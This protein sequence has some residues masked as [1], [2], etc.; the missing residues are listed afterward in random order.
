[1]RIIIAVTL[2]CWFTHLA[3]GAAHGAEPPR[4]TTALSFTTYVAG[5]TVM[6]MEADIDIGRDSYRVDLASRTAGAYGVLFRGETRSTAQ[7]R[8]VGPLVAPQRF[9][10]SGHWRGTPRRTLMDYESGLPTILNLQ[11]PNDAEREPVPTALQRETIDAISAAA[12]LV[13]RATESAMCEGS[14]RTFDGRRLSQVS[15]RTVGWEMLA[16]DSRSSFAGRALRCDF[17][18]QL[19]AGFMLQGDR[20]AAAR[21]QNGTAWL[22]RPVEGAPMLPVR[23]RFEARWIGSATTYLTAATTQGPPLVRVRADAENGA[24]PIRQ[25]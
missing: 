11:P 9:A 13:R 1:M 22:A 10:V 19:L 15:V 23:L 7:G 18:G 21:P 2:A 16:P 8:W 25:P 5:M 4:A 6:T 17:D 3:S 24:V 20:A 12:L 14:T